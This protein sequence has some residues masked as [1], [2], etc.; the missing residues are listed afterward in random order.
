MP[1]N[2]KIQFQHGIVPYRVM[3]SGYQ[4]LQRSQLLLTAVGGPSVFERNLQCE[5]VR[6]G[7]T[8]EE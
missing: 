3:V 8:R 1:V 4:L 5:L 7:E 2:C 6:K